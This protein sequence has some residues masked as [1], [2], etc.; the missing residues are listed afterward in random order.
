MS[1]WYSSFLIELR[2]VSPG[3]LRLKLID[4]GN[5]VPIE[6]LSLYYSDFEIQ[7]VQYR[8]PEVPPQCVDD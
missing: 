3:S 5:A 8:A 2:I 1:E 6:R 4:L 7:S